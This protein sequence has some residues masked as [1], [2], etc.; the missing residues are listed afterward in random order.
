[1]QIPIALT[2]VAATVLVVGLF[3]QALK[4][5]PLQEP[6]L[7]V[8][9]GIAVGPHG[10]GW[11]DV[12]AWGN[13][14]ELLEQTAHVTLAIGLMA[15]A[16]RISSDDLRRY[17]RPAAWLLTLGMLGMWLTSSLAAGWLLDLPPSGALLLGAVLTPT[18]P[19]V[20]STIVTG[21]FAHQHLPRRI[22]SFLSL[23]SGA[24]DGLAYLFVLLP[25]LLI[26]GVDSP[27]RDW[28]VQAL[29]RGVVVAALLGAAI[30]FGAG[31]ILHRAHKGGLIESYSFL[32]FTT[33][34]SLFTLG[35]ASLLRADAL[36]SVFVA[37]LTFNLS[38]DT[39]ERHE[40]E[41]IQE[42]MSKLFTLPMFVLFG[43]AA[44]LDDWA[45]LG[46]PLA[47]LAAAVLLLRRLPVVG[48]LYPALRRD[49]AGSDI[50][51][52][53]WF[54]PLGIAAVY[55]STYAVNETGQTSLWTAASAVIA[56]S[57]LA[58]GVTAAPLTRLY[59]RRNRA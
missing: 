29:L 41:R 39:G 12:S 17:A 38:T 30:G 34:L 2:V 51:F 8:A 15:V 11:L 22:R 43:L 23:E 1:M 47:A 6:L 40:E 28:L 7:G 20:A 50:A 13:P 27:P 44:P 55:Y 45:R 58:H 35:A 36:I 24:N 48:L 4:R 26:G 37:G 19:V 46:A 25:I 31:K 3:S 9:V 18:D 57:I 49:Y 42:S 21:K 10:I 52:I 56:A 32:T 59:S 14:H 53:G 5:T 16:L 54:G 33:T